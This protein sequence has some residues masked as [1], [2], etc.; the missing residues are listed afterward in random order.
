MRFMHVMYVC[1]VDMDMEDEDDDS[2]LSIQETKSEKTALPRPRDDA[3]E[4]IVA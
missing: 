3:S 1:Q 4:G 2:L